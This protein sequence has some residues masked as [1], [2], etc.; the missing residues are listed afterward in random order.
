MIIFDP[1]TKKKQTI[2][3]PVSLIDLYPTFVDYANVKGENRKNDKGLPI[4]GSSL[5]PLI[6]G[7]ESL[8]DTKERF[9]LTVVKLWGK[10]GSK[11]F[12]IRKKDW[13]YIKYGNN[14]EE[15]YHNKVDPN[16][17]FN[18]ADIHQYAVIKTQLKNKLEQA[19]KNAK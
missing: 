8:V 15:L 12:S 14:K 18:L 2:V 10:K 1:R 4:S 5:K 16:E 13:R 7:Q 6:E 19:T 11:S 3:D 17:I 9:A